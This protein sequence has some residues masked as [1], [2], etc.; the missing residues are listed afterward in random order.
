MGAVVGVTEN[1]AFGIALLNKVKVI[2]NN[3]ALRTGGAVIIFVAV[4][5]LEYD[6]LYNP[7]TN[8]YKC[9]AHT[10]LYDNDLKKYK[11]D[12]YYCGKLLGQI[13]SLAL[14]AGG[15]VIGAKMS[16]YAIERYAYART[17]APEVYVADS[18]VPIIKTNNKE[19]V[20]DEVFDITT[21]SGITNATAAEQRALAIK[22]QAKLIDF[23]NTTVQTL[24][25]NL[26]DSSLLG[27]NLEKVGVIRPSDTA[28][29]HIVG[30]SDSRA[31]ASRLKLQ[32]LGIDVDEASNGV[33]LPNSTAVS[34]TNICTHSLIHTSKYFSYVEAQIKLAP[35]ALEARNI[36]N[37]IRTQLLNKEDIY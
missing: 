20:S 14:E 12:S 18:T 15:L 30:A 7:D 31:I 17:L 3:P 16:V 8:Y 33:F 5:Y 37:K 9:M 19:I 4:M 10:T 2:T 1:T 29:H 32:Q 34:C 24:K 26:G 11:T 21:Q 22:N 28:V 25:N 35:N 23:S 27:K 36:L 6:Q 13:V